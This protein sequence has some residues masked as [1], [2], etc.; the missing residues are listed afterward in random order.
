[1]TGIDWVFVLGTAAILLTPGPTNT[2][3]AAAG[4]AQGF[5]RAA[6]LVAALVLPFLAL[7]LYLHWGASDKVE[8]ARE[9][10]TAPKSN[11]A[12]NAYNAARADVRQYG[13]AEVPLH[14]RNAPT[15][16]MKELGYG[17]EYQYD[18]FLRHSIMSVIR[19]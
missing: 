12:Y 4:L 13:T 8:L 5:R 15:K 7:G 17:A 19:I 1:M 6:P 2:L 16:L 14:L 9:F 10:A 11:A 3:L 18:G